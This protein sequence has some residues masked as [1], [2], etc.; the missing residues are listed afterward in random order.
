M[1]ALA[2]PANVAQIRHPHIVN[3]LEVMS[4]K[5]KI[6]MVMELVTGGELFD[7]VVADGPMKVCVCVW[8]G[9][10]GERGG[11]SWVGGLAT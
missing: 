11:G 1:H 7:K 5:D 8:V 10:R 2:Q 9:G 6:F 3:L 4:S